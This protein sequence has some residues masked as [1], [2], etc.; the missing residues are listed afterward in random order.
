MTFHI[1]AERVLDQAPGGLTGMALEEDSETHG[2]SGEKMKQRS[3][4]FFYPGKDVCMRAKLLQSCPTL[5]D[6]M[7]CSLPGSSVQRL[8]QARIL[9]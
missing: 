3:Q 2:S 7:D 1:N 4:C 8:L 6:P 5:R 9:G